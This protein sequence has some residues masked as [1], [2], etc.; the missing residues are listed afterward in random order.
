MNEPDAY[1]AVDA[2]QEACEA[3][4]DARADWLETTT[5]QILTRW[6]AELK[7]DDHI[8][9]IGYDG[10]DITLLAIE[11]QVPFDKKLFDL[12][13]KFADESGLYEK[14]SWS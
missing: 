7:E 11:A 1:W 12:A 4:S 14:L 9:D 3:V 5:L 13:W 10:A 2:L 8:A 6:N